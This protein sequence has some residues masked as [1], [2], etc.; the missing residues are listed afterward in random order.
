LLENTFQAKTNARKLQ[1][2]REMNSLR[3]EG[4]EPL[5]RY[6][7]RALTKWAELTTTG[8]EMRE[9]EAV[10]SALNGLPKQYGTALAIL[11]ASEVELTFSAALSKL[12]VVEQRLDRHEDEG[13]KAFYHNAEGP[14]YEGGAALYHHASKG[15]QRWRPRPPQG[16]AGPSQPG[17]PE[18][19]RLECYYCHRVGHIKRD[20]RKFKT[21]QQKS[22]GETPVAMGLMAAAMVNTHTRSSGEP[23]ERCDNKWNVD[24][25]ATHHMTFCHQVMTNTRV[26]DITVMTGKGPLKAT[27]I[28][29]VLLTPTGL[30]P[31]KLSNV[32]LVPGL[33]FNLVSVSACT[34]SG[35]T[36]RMTD[37]SASIFKGEKLLV[38]AACEGG[39]YVFQ[40]EY[41]GNPRAVVKATALVAKEQET[42]ELWHARFGHLGYRSM[43]KLPDLV[44]GIQLG[45]EAFEV[46]ETTVCEGCELGKLHR[47]IFPSSGTTTTKPL[48]LLHTDVCG[49]M[50]EPSLGGNLYFTTVLDD[51]SGY[52]IAE[53]HRHKSDAE[54]IVKRAVN[55]LENATDLKV[56]TIRSD[57]GGEF[58]NEALK[59]FYAGKGIQQQATAPY[60][61]EQNGKA[62]RLNRVL[63]ER[64]RSMIHGRKLPLNLWAEALKTANY[65]RNRSP[66]LQRDKTPIE[67]LTGKRP[68]VGHM[69]IFGSVAYV[70]TPKQLRT[71]LDPVGEK[72]IFLGY[73]AMSKAYRFLVEGRVMVSRNAT[74]EEL[75]TNA[76]KRPRAGPTHSEGA[77]VDS[78]SERVSVLPP[79]AGEGAR[80]ES[81]DWHSPAREAAP[82]NS[83]D[84]EWHTP[85]GEVVAEQPQ[86]LP[87]AQQLDVAE[88]VIGRRVS[89]AFPQ[90]RGRPKLYT[91]TVTGQ[92]TEEETGRCIYRINYDDGDIDDRYREELNLLPPDAQLPRRSG[93][94]KSVPK[95]A[96]ALT[97]KAVSQEPRTVEEALSGSDSDHWREDEYRSL[98]ENDTW[99]LV[100]ATP[101]IK[102]IPVKW[103]FKIKRDAAGK[104]ERYKARLVVKGFMQREGIDFEEVFAPVSKHT[105]LRAL[106]A[107]AAEQDLELHQLDIKTAFLN[108]ELEEQVYM[109]QPPG[110]EDGT[111]KICHLKKTLYGLR[112][113][114]RQWHLKLVE[115]LHK[116][117]AQAS[118]A[119][120]G[121]YV[122]VAQEATVFLLIWVDDILLASSS[123]A[124]ISLAKKALL[125][126]FDA[127]D[128]GEA[129]FFVGL[130]IER[131]RTNRSIKLAQK[132]ANTDL[133]TKFGMHEAKS[134]AVPLSVATKLTLDE[135]HPLDTTKYPYSELVGGLLYLAVCTRPDIAQATGCLAR[136]MAQP[137]V[138]HWNAALGVLRY[139]AST[140]DLGI[141]YE[142]SYTSD[143][144]KGYADADFAGDID[145]RRSTT[146]YVFTLSGG[147]ISWSSRLQ[148]TVAVSTAEAEYMAAAFAVK[149][150]LWLRKLMADL[151]L[152][153]KPVKIYGDNQSALKL[154]KHPIASLRSKHIDVIYHFARER[155]ARG[156]VKFEYLKTEDMVADIMTKPLPE[157]KFEKCRDAMGMTV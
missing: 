116:M 27:H 61:P 84:P 81:P 65:I 140:Q 96:S 76:I 139:L 137:A 102:P 83:P 30:G 79:A 10:W 108:G 73:D 80:A 26:C 88:Q 91:G 13:A 141:T 143:D 111:G 39:L 144:L 49:P 124:A 112:Q 15:S 87:G 69:R 130:S 151:G 40:A 106:L 7:N 47:L 28:G 23:C 41:L 36:V 128:L 150:A 125:S 12:L 51:Y 138:S 22:K 93:R 35:A 94:A 132:L 78:D 142:P 67:M 19:S 152:G 136:Y 134:R 58:L 59:D 149:E 153:M 107:I 5:T 57:R 135:D 54:D 146:G 110:Y 109:K 37:I 133:V 56:K 118:D 98:L 115:I 157:A 155:A 31:V 127:R 82:P 33:P 120:P 17:R 16:G 63:V 24:S 55:M 3:K 32:L 86:P 89:V 14:D 104:I 129:K 18:H 77:P 46:K 75:P 70:H 62:E 50:K 105:T 71:K 114:P 74:I 43:A 68:K 64:T 92:D 42:A 131:K 25:G 11:E 1:L 103:V 44:D 145:T 123:L 21:D 90:E 85:E 66:Y 99:E 48:E 52:S 53:P 60:S 8:H 101:G 156:E 100:D 147:A 2:R 122:L 34:D 72:G 29:D 121:L 6:F 45:K 119:D 9:N 38:D 126:A 113:A 154:I 148:P 20:C 97:M 4:A 117:G 95:K